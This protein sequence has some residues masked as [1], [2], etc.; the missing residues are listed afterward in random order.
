M[1]F[2]N[3]KTFKI[4]LAIDRENYRIYT[5]EDISFRRVRTFEP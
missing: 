1:E 4:I 2:C 3:P 5:L